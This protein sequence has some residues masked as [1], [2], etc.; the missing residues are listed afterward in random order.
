MEIKI[1]NKEFSVCKVK[2][3]SKV[4]Y[5]DEFCFIGKTDEELSLV[6]STNLVPDNTIE[7][8]NEWKAFRIQG[9]LDF[10]LIG[11]LSKLSTLLADNQIGI[12]AIS[13]Y[14]T[15]YILVKKDNF[16]KAI[17]ILNQNGYVTIR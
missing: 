2:D 10:S 13:T 8:D 11:I 5:S 4:D 7:C 15:D 14:N 9:I 1:I 6:C 12:F 3:L 16:E 17:K